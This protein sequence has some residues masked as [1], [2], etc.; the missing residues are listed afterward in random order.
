MKSIKD[1]D[2]NVLTEEEKI[3][4]RWKENYA[5]LYNMPGPSDTSII[6]TIPSTQTED[7]EPD[8]LKDEVATALK[9]LKEGKAAGFDGIS[10]EEMKA[11]GEIGIDVIHKLCRQIWESEQIPND[12]GKAVIVPIFKM[13]D[14]LDCANY[15][16]ISLLS[17][18]GKVFCSIIHSRMKKKTEEILSE[19][20]AGFRPGRSTADQLFSL[21][22]ITEK[23]NEIGKPL[24][25]C[26]IDYQKAFD[27]VWQEGLWSAMRHLGYPDKIVRL[28][29]ALYQISTSAVRVDD[30]ITEWFRTL[31]G[32]RQGCILS[33]QLFNI[34]L[35]L[36][37]SL[38]IQDLNIG[39]NLQGMTINNLRFADDIVLLAD[40]VED[41]QTLVTNIHT[42]SRKFGLTINKGKTEVQIITKESKPMSV[43]I[44]EVQLKQVE[45]FT[46]LGGVISENSTCTDDI[47]RRIGLAMGG[48]QKLTSIWKSKEITTETKIELYRVLILSIATYGSES[49][50]L[51]KRDEHRLLV[52]EMSCLRRILGVSRRDKLRNSSIRETTKCQ[53]PIV[54]KI[55]AKQ[56]S[57]FGHA[58]RM[59][60]HRYPKITLEGRIPGQRPRGRPPKRWI[61]NIKAS[62]QDIGIASVCEAIRL[63]DDRSVWISLVKRLLSPRIPTEPKGGQ[64]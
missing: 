60:N 62:C 6:Q 33:P 57:Y 52:F 61:D 53:T 25:L 49:W 7:I 17:L 58:I 54:D 38:A 18:V 43:Y 32:V 20:Q 55:K 51:K 50:T 3:K 48:M 28:L 19:S 21:R 47:R 16:G 31:T 13:K 4:D 12:W 23:Y 30:D 45:T 8:I 64:H 11:T 56:L 2:G 9:H 34:L 42:V 63:I 15:R 14:K 1:K 35:E 39:I 59:P 24:Y 40:S 46:Y 10:A 22:Q 26:Y 44:D 36:V 41:L 29:Q 37:I 27:T 5:D